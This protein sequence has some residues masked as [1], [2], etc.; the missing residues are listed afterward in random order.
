M[1]NRVSA[2]GP[3]EFGKALFGVP[4]P[5]QLGISLREPAPG[6]EFEALP[7]PFARIGEGAGPATLVLGRLVVPGK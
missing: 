6:T 2:F 1:G 7:D 3:D 4:A 5:A